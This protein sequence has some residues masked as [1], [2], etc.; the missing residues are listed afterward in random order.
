MVVLGGGCCARNPCR[1]KGADASPHT[2]EPVVQGS[3]FIARERESERERWETRVST[4]RV[5]RSIE[6]APR[7]SLLD[8]AVGCRVQRIAEVDSSCRPLI[9]PL[10]RGSSR[11]ESLILSHHSRFTCECNKEEIND[12]DE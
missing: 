4:A 11:F 12:D 1:V 9:V 5:E 3:G 6:Q 10:F 8:P 7:N 2:P